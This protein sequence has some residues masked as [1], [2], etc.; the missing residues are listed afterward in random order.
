MQL[1]VLR[2]GNTFESSRQ[3]V[4]IGQR[5]DLP[6]VAEGRTQIRT[7]GEHLRSLGFAPAAILCGPLRRAQESARL[8]CEALGGTREPRVDTR[9]D[10]L[11]YGL[12]EGLSSAEVEERFGSRALRAWEDHA[13]WPAEAEWGGSRQQIVAE[14]DS[15]LQELRTAYPHDATVVL[16]SSGGRLRHLHSLVAERGGASHEANPGNNARQGGAV[17]RGTPS[18]L[19]TAHAGMLLT[20][21]DGWRMAFWNRDPRTLTKQDLSGAG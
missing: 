13:N 19:R 6:L 10:E 4:W 7:A 2:H 9:L 15:L 11:D 1:L 14:L 8:L 3:A 16:V 20:L 21:A 5:T 17:D 12:W 18:K